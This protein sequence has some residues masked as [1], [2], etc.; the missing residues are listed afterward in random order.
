M[1]HTTLWRWRLALI[2]LTLAI[3]PAKAAPVYEGVWAKTAADCRVTDLP[4]SKTLI[5]FGG[6]GRPALLDQY[7]NHCRIDDRAAAAGGVTLTVTCFE[8]W[9][10][11]SKNIGGRPATIRLTPARGNGLEIDGVRY[12]RCLAN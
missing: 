11:Y 4:T 5:D 3:S 2:A 8:F 7:E 9:E 12:R 10:E 6:P 1:Q